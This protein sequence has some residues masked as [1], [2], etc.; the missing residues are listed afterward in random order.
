MFIFLD[1]SQL[2]KLD[3]DKKLTNKANIWSSSNELNIRV[4]NI[5]S[6][7]NFE[8]IEKIPYKNKTFVLQRGGPNTDYFA[9]KDCTSSK[10]LTAIS[11]DSL[12]IKG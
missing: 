2:W 1:S 5:T 7:G 6:E 11:E 9:L 8:Y 10:V 12:E 4:S 3:D